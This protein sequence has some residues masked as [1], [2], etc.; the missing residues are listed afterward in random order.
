MNSCTDPVTSNREWRYR[1]ESLERQHTLGSTMHCERD[2]AVS[3]QWEAAAASEP[4]NPAARL[5][6]KGD[7]GPT[8]SSNLNDNKVMVKKDKVI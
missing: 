6:A 8:S 2:L 3:K 5:T 1:F 4:E 7:N